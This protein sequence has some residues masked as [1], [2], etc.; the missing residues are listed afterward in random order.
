MPERVRELTDGRGVD[1]VY[2]SVG[3]TTFQGSIDSLKRRGML[4]SFG[5]SSGAVPPIDPLVLSRKGSLFLTRPT[6]AHYIADREELEQR[7]QDIFGW[8][9]DGNLKIRIDSEFVLEH[10]GDAHRALES[11]KT[12]GKVLIIP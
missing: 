4:V 12:A 2:D 5:Q 7:A 11:R 1:V 6:L 8:M 10:A 3:K 9:Q